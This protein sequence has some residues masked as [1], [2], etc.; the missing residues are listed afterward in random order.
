M[1]IFD[2]PQNPHPQ[3]NHT[4]DY[5]GVPV[6]LPNL[7]QI[8]PQWAS[9]QMVKGK[10]FFN[11]YLFCGNSPAG[12]THRLIYTLDGLN[13]ADT[14]KS[15]LFGGFVDIAPHFVVE[16]PPQPLPPFWGRE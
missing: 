7:V 9:G 16:I 5:V 1:A 13:D 3:T 8:H 14:R 10:E 4:A 6:A 15:V 12:Q 2:P 11:L